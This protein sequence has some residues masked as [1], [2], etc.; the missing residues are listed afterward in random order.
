MILGV[1]GN[2]SSF[3]A[4]YTLG[5]GAFLNGDILSLSGTT[6]TTPVGTTLSSNAMLDFTT[7][8]GVNFG[9]TIATNAI[10][11]GHLLFHVWWRPLDATGACA[12]GTGGAL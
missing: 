11:D 1:T 6:G 2:T 8:G 4:A 7:V 10:T 9:Y 3:M 5:A 12:A